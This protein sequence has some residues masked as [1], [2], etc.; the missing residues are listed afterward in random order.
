MRMNV[1]RKCF[2]V[3]NNDQILRLRSYD[4]AKMMSDAIFEAFFL[5]FNPE[6]ECMCH[7]HIY[8][9]H[10]SQESEFGHFI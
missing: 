2:F 6:I 10:L 1:L 7:I 8:I 5:K 4:K 9:V 3:D